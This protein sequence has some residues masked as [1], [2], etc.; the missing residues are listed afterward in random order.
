M[1]IKE[2]FGVSIDW[3]LTGEEPPDF[4][5]V[6]PIITLAG[7][8]PELP[9]G[10]RPEY[11]LAVPLVEGPIAAGYAGAIPGDQVQDLVWVY[12]PEIG[13]REHHNLRAVRLAPDADSME[14]TIRRGSIVIIDPVEVTPLPK[15]I[16]AVRLDEEGGC[17][18]KR[19]SQTE[20]HWVLIS[21]NP[22]YPPIALEKVRMPN[23]IIGRV[24]W[25][26]TSWV[27]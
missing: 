3:L 21:D 15:G 6:Q 18:I 25:S 8:Q 12:K 19:V 23:L 2:V 24:I 10:L 4:Q 7:T 9:E 17:A 14:P 26:W 11:Y 1:V 27:R 13:A 5:T 20:H 22:E 16:Y